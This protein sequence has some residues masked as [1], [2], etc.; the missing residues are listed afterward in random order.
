M[1]TSQRSTQ[2]WLTC[3]GMDS[4]GLYRETDCD[5]LSRWS[6]R[7]EAQSCLSCKVEDSQRGADTHSARV[8]RMPD[9]YMYS[10]AGRAEV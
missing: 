4:T 1:R 7:K 6:T 9:V 3:L 2:R 5:A 8:L 10:I